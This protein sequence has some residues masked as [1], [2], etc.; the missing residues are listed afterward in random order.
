MNNQDVLDKQF[1]Q[2]LSIAILTTVGNLKYGAHPLIRSIQRMALTSN[3]KKEKLTD[4]SSDCPSFLLKQE[5]HKHEL[6][7]TNSVNAICSSHMQISAIF[8]FSLF[9]SSQ[10]Q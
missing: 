8:T 4:T 3:R 7:D 6:C 9:F 2:V 1:F 5:W 10:T